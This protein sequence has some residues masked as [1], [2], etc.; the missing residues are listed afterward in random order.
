MDS[1]AIVEIRNNNK[2]TTHTSSWVRLALVC[3]VDDQ[4]WNLRKGKITFARELESR[5]REQVRDEKGGTA[6]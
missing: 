3:V 5:G 6:I 2:E 1:G 4:Q